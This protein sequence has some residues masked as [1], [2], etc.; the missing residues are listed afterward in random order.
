V[1]GERRR[2]LRRVLPFLLLVVGLGYL[3]I[4]LLQAQPVAVEVT[5]HYGGLRRGL[6]AASMRYLREGEELRRVHFRYGVRP[7]GTTQVHRIAVP[8]GDYTVALELE[9]EGRGVTRLTR[10]L[11]VAGEGRVSIYVDPGAD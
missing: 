1:T 3:V 6:R 10:P 2:W 9:H 7:A 4:R 8:E 11:I 5:Y